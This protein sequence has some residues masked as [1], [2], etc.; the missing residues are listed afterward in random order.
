LG[1]DRVLVALERK[2]YKANVNQV[3]AYDQKMIYRIR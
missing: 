1:I 2:R 3:K